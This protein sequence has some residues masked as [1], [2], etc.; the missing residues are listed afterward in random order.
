M[1]KIQTLS[2]EI[3]IRFCWAAEVPIDFSLDLKASRMEGK[4]K[5]PIKINRWR[6][7]PGEGKPVT[8]VR[9]ELK[10]KKNMRIMA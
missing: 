9:R 3:L 2:R 4:E 5:G 1:F 8:S 6:G 10:R 7:M